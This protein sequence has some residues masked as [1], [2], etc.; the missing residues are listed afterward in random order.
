MDSFK[1]VLFKIGPFFVY[2]YL[3]LKQRYIFVVIRFGANA[4]TELYQHGNSK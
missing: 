4:L 2:F 3:H 1:D